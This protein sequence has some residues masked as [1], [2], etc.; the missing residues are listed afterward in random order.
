MAGRKTQTRRAPTKRRLPT[1]LKAQ[2]LREM[3]AE[4]LA[5]DEEIAPARSF[6]WWIFR[7][8]GK[9][10]L[11]WNYTFAKPGNIIASRRLYGHVVA[12][13]LTSIGFWV[14]LIILGGIAI[15]GR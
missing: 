12:E 5:E 13:V 9:T 11:W 3:K 2:N 7:A 14:A 6:T 15:A 1:R 8:P 10:I 4:I